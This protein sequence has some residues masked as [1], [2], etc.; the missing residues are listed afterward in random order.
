MYCLRDMLQQ[1]GKNSLILCDELTAGTENTSAT[2]I[3]AAATAALIKQQTQFIFT[4]HLHGLADFPEITEHPKLSVYH[5]AVMIEN[6]SIIQN[7][8]LVPGSG[9]YQYGIEIADALGL[10]KQFIKM[11]YEFRQKYQ[12]SSMSILSNKRSRYNSKVIVDH[13]TQCGMKPCENS[14][15]YLHVHHIAEQASADSS[16]KI[17]GKAFHK[18]I[19]HNLMVLCEQCHNQIHH[20]EQSR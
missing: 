6:G 2:G 15:N 8:K 18:N 1:S 7:R 5:F 13:R 20:D 4:T 3:V 9:S 16:G 14:S 17:T 19:A 12:G 11:A 10:P